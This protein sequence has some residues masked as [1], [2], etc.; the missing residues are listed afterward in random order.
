MIFLVLD[1]ESKDPFIGLELG[2]GW[3]FAIHHPQNS[4]FYPIGYSYCYYNSEDGSISKSEYIGLSTT[5]LIQTQQGHKNWFRYSKLID[6]IKQTKNIVC[7]NA[8]YDLGCLLSLGIS[9]DHLR[10][11]DT[12]V[13]GQLYDSSLWSYSLS[14]L[15]NK[16]NLGTKQTGTLGDIVKKFDLLKTR[17]GRSPDTSTKTYQ[18]R[19][20]DFAYSNMDLLQELD[21]NSMAYYA[22]HD[23][24]GTAALFKFYYKSIGDKLSHYYSNIQKICVKIRAKGIAVDMEAIDKGI[25]TITPVFYSLQQSLWQRLSIELNLNASKD[26]LGPRLVEMRYKLPLTDSGNPSVNREFLEE[27]PNDPLCQEISKYRTVNI[28]LKDFLIKIKDMQQHSCPEVIAGGK[29]GKVFPELNLLAART[30]RF[31]SSNPNIQ[32][33]PKRD[34]EFAKLCRAMFVPTNRDNYWFSLDWSNQEGRLQ[35]HYANRQGFT[36]ARDWLKRFKEDPKIDTHSIVAKMMGGVPRDTAKTIYLG[37]SFCMGRAKTA[38]RLGMETAIVETQRGK[39]ETSGP[40]A[41]KLIEKYEKSFPYLTELQKDCMKTIVDKGYIKTLGGRKCKRPPMIKGKNYDYKA[42]SLLIQG[43]AADQM[44]AALTQADEAGIDIKCIIHDEFNIEGQI[45]DA[46]TMQEIMQ[47]CANIDVPSIAEI[48]MGK[49][50]GDLE[51]IE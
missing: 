6:L 46:K 26:Q 1:F 19:A 33:I 35:L 39:M 34:K 29:Y 20:N 43:S 15:L 42:I 18:K 45:K 7:H 38:K 49:S 50:W 24:M 17:M 47:T 13:M 9:I 32:N 14:F 21:F 31:S 40:E 11:Y 12:K 4:L 3:P 37:K 28:L 36:G 25:E 16:Y 30:G 51:E 5:G 48:K 10:V 41:T 44:Y 8:Q 23:T 2:A 22:N 27:N